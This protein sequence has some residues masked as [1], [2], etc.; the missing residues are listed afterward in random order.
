MAVSEDVQGEAK[1]RH[2]LGLND[3]Q[4][5]AESSQAGSNIVRQSKSLV[6]ELMVVQLERERSGVAGTCC[7]VDGDGGTASPVRGDGERD[8]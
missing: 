3:R 4:G 1:V 2:A 8:G 5:E 6:E 7:P